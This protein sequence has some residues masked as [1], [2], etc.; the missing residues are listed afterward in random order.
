MRQIILRSKVPYPIELITIICTRTAFPIKQLPLLRAFISQL[1]KKVK[2]K[3]FVKRL[4]YDQ[5]FLLEFDI[6]IIC[7]L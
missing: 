5:V 3:L 1:K 6:T 2:K 7:A 4:N